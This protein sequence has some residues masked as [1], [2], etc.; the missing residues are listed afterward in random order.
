MN[1]WIGTKLI[2]LKIKPV[3]NTSNMKIYESREYNSNGDYEFSEYFATKKERDD[4]IKERA[5]ATRGGKVE[6]NTIELPKQCYLLN[7]SQSV[8]KT[9]FKD[10]QKENKHLNKILSAVKQA[11]YNELNS[12]V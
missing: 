4:R 10:L 6:S 2:K 8:S 12:I 9:E 7:T 5:S 3:Y 11:V 1:V